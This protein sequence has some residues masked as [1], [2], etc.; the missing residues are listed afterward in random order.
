MVAYREGSRWADRGGIVLLVDPDSPADVLARV[1]VTL[2][3]A[4]AAGWRGWALHPE[5][6]FPLGR[7]LEMTLI[8]DWLSY[9][10]AIAQGVDPTPIPTIDALKAALE[11]LS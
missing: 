7:V 4:S 1:E 5:S 2:D 10:I 9:W 3:L 6:R 11:R 8:G